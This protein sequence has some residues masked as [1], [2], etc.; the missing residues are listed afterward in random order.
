MKLIIALLLSVFLLNPKAGATPQTDASSLRQQVVCTGI[1]KRLRELQIL[2]FSIDLT[3]YTAANDRLKEHYLEVC[4]AERFDE[5]ALAAVERD[6]EDLDVSLAYLEILV[7]RRRRAPAP[8]V[9]AP[10]EARHKVCA[11]G[12]SY[13][14]WGIWG[15]KAHQARRSCHNSGDAIDIHAIRCNGKVQSPRTAAARFQKYV[16]CMKGNFN[17]IFG[18]RQHRNH[19]HIELKN[20]RRVRGTLQG[21]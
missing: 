14:S 9:L 13:V 17:V 10:F 2:S 20:C 1:E 4:E 3:A 11:P 18:N 7:Q 15:D 16:G 8:R 12:C 21:K 6:L 19:A 5:H